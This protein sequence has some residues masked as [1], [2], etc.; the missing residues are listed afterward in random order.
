MLRPTGVFSRN[1]SIQLS[2]RFCGTAKKGVNDA[3]RGVG[4]RGC[5]AVYPE[6]AISPSL[7][8]SRQLTRELLAKPTAPRHA[9]PPP[10]QRGRKR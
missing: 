2:L 8:E 5:F 4:V 3:S 6:M 9:D 7:E 1:Q 10:D